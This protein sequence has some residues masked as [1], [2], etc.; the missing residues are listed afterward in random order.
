MIQLRS[1][2]R[3]PLHSASAAGV[4]SA[5]AQRGLTMVELL[6][7]M[8]IGLLI[9]LAAISALLISRQGFSAEIGRAHV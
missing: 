5:V 3:N 6:V 8:V 2:R 4:P 9:S 1:N 7:A